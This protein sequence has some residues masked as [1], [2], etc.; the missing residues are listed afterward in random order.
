M[1]SSFLIGNPSLSSNIGIRVE[2][3]VYLQKR[4]LWVRLHEKDGKRQAV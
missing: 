1:S 4:R 2:E 3:D